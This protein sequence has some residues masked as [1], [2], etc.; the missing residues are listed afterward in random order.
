[1][2]E[3]RIRIIDRC[4]ISDIK[5][6]GTQN[7]DLLFSQS[8]FVGSDGK[9]YRIEARE[10]DGEGELFDVSLVPASEEITDWP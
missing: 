4:G 8:T 5:S 3:V 1:M 6:I 2:S 9:M 10:C 7:I